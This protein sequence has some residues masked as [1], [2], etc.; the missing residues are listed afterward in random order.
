M[1]I[2]SAPPTP[3]I[4]LQLEVRGDREGG[5]YEQLQGDG[6]ELSMTQNPAYVNV[7]GLLIETEGNYRAQGQFQGQKTDLTIVPEDQIAQVGGLNIQTGTIYHVDG[8]AAGQ[9]VRGDIREED[10]I[11]NFGGISVQTDSWKIF[12]GPGVYYEVHDEG[13]GHRITGQDQGR[14]IDLTVQGLNGGD[15]F[16]LQGQ[17]APDTLAEIVTLRPFLSV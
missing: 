17:A 15:E 1:H 7:G 16:I 10:K 5:F 12:E 8:E 2:T 4:R 14:P 3:Q 13:E 11:E 9:A 6:V